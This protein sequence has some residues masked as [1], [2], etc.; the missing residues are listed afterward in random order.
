LAPGQTKFLTVVLEPPFSTVTD[1]NAALRIVSSRDTVCSLE[2]TIIPITANIRRVSFDVVPDS[3]KSTADLE[4]ESV[5][6]Y[7]TVSNTGEGQLTLNLSMSG[8]SF[9][10]LESADVITLDPE[11]SDSIKVNFSPSQVGTYT[12]TVTVTD[13][14]C[15]TS[16]QVRFIVTI[17]QG[18]VVLMGNNIPGQQ[19]I[20][21][22]R[23]GD[24]I[25]IPVHL[26][27]SV[28]LTTGSFQGDIALTFD[29]NY[30][31]YD[32]YPLRVIPVSVRS[33]AMA[34]TSEL[35]VTQIT[36]RDSL[37]EEGHLATIVMEVLLGTS[38]ST[39][40]SFT[41]PEFTPLVAF[42]TL[43]NNT[44]GTVNL[45]PR[46]GFLTRRD[47]GIPWV[48]GP[49]PN[50]VTTSS[51]QSATVEYNVVKDGHVEIRVFNELGI[52]VG[53]PVNGWMPKG[54]H[55]VRIETVN[56]PNGMYHILYRTGSFHASQKLILG[57]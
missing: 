39:E 18:S 21:S 51:G 30:N 49:A 33:G 25:E 17:L 32:L 1:I 6:L 5:S 48:G 54:V 16:D 26:S 41:D 44:T 4:D 53:V 11:Q 15:Q 46:N 38:S 35:G 57:R 47:L 20:L 31:F 10:T 34:P 3:V 27:E 8:S 7:A 14:V 55:T 2:P 22:S 43:D 45:Q 37:F 40:W 24:E 28:N 19:L 56:L 23:P 52:E 42:V 29:L 50:P 12:A 9:F 36:L 13:G